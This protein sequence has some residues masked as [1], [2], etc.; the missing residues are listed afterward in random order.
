MSAPRVD[1]F[2]QIIEIEFELKM[3]RISYQRRI[4]DGHLD[5]ADAKYRIRNMEAVLKTLEDLKASQPPP[6]QDLHP[7]R[8]A[9]Q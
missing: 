6:T 8:D 7:P 9:E 4:D 2:Q 5:A 3:R 1:L